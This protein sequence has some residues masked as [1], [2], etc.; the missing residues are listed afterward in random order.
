MPKTLPGTND[1]VLCFLE[2]ESIE[3]SAQQQLRNIASLPFIHGHVAVMPDCHLGMG[4]TVGSVI[5]TDGAIVPS[6]VGVDIGCGMIAVLTTLFAVDLPDNLRDLRDGIEKRVPLGAGGANQELETSARHRYERL[7]DS[8]YYDVRRDYS[9]LSKRWHLQ[10]GT[11]GSGNHFIELCLDKSDRVW[12]V[13]HSGSRGIGNRLA[14]EHINKAKDLMKEYFISLPDKDL[15]YLVEGT[16]AFN[17]YI[18][19][20]LWAQQYALANRDEMMDRVMA[21]LSYALYG[22]SGRDRWLEIDRIQC[23]HNFTQRENHGGKNLWVTRKGAIETRANMKGVIPGSMGTE[24]YIVSGLGN[25]ASYNSAPHGAGRRFSRTEARRRF[26]MDDFDIAMA[27]IEHRRSESLIDELP[28]AYKDIN[29]VMENA[30]DLV[31][32]DHTLRQ[33][34]NVKGD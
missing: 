20:L 27:G 34:L 18:C 8:K 4:A 13:L 21:E 22:V 32:I 1:K 31:K 23:H 6:A 30:K 17:A 26:T 11:L 24:S 33:I 16:D 28:G 5:A 7:V 14:Q 9:K 12:T 2:P 25:A 10:I 3:P 15:A 19:D 29:E